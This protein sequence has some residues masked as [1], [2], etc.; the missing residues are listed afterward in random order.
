MID[1]KFITII[2]KAYSV[3]SFKIDDFYLKSCISDK[4]YYGKTQAVAIMDFINEN[5][6]WNI[7]FNECST[8]R[9]PEDDYIIYN[10]GNLKIEGYYRDIEEQIIKYERK[11]KIQNCPNNTKF[12]VQDSRCYNGNAVTFWK[13]DRKGYTT[14]PNDMLILSKQD[15]L[16]EE[17]RNTDSFWKLDD[18][19]K[20]VC[21]YCN[22]E[23]LFQYDRY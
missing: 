23:K 16:Q 7:Q 18:V 6:D 11:K 13:K 22:T 15:I 17:W 3:D 9:E 10:D 20:S 1:K 4:R 14:D 5:C 8:K 12:C 2:K 19:L 21:Q